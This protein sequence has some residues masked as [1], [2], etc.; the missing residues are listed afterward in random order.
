M[1]RHGSADQ[2]IPLL[3]AE[4]TYLFTNQGSV[5]WA[6]KTEPKCSM[7]NCHEYDSVFCECRLCD[8][9]FWSPYKA[10]FVSDGISSADLDI[11]VQHLKPGPNIERALDPNLHTSH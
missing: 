7:I 10:L 11:D 2:I 8:T 3:D 4:T 6:G 5:T 1:W 9:A